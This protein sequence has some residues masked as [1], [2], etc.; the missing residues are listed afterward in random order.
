METTKMTKEERATKEKFWK[1]Y[2]ELKY[3]GG[4]FMCSTYILEHPELSHQAKILFFII[5][6]FSAGKGYCFARTKTLTK[7]V[8]LKKTA[9]T[10]Y[11]NELEAIGFIKR[12]N[13]NSQ[14]GFNRKIFIN[15]D[16]IFRMAIK[17][18][19]VYRDR[20]ENVI[21]D[22]VFYKTDKH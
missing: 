12:E 3:Y 17:D 20:S 5:S 21:P 4:T 22:E 13:K 18:E 11:L 1:S 15:F 6:S 9:I 19:K 10:T 8:Q 7:K 14:R 16:Y 2:K